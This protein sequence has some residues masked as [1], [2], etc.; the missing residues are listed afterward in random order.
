MN[1]DKLELTEAGK[2]YVSD[3]LSPIKFRLGMLRKLPSLV[4]W[5][6]KM[7]HLD[8]HSCKV[9]IPYSWRSQNPFRSIYFAALAG[10]GELSTGLLLDTML[11]GRGRWSML[12]I[13]F[14]AEFFKKATGTIV[15]EC[16][17]G[18]KIQ[19]AIQLAESGEPQIIETI[20]AGKL[21]DGNIATQFKIIWSIKKK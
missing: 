1:N 8:S 3:L 2:K 17:D 9:L 10:A 19:R 7:V 20:T 18:K 12:V 6:V 21:S 4:F 13:G 11:K 5:G 15:F 14:E 16:A